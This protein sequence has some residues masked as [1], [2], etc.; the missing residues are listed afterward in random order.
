M[1]W[2]PALLLPIASFL[3]L[4][5]LLLL[6]SS[7]KGNICIL[8]KFIQCIH[9]IS[10]LCFIYKYHSCKTHLPVRI[11]S[12]PARRVR[13]YLYFLLKGIRMQPENFVFIFLE[14]GGAPNFKN[15]TNGGTRT[16][17]CARQATN[18]IQ[19][20]YTQLNSIGLHFSAQLCLYSYHI[21]DVIINI[22][23]PS[24]H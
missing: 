3:A 10:L 24:S 11:S 22:N 21:Y 16:R 14:M 2:T 8:I 20:D 4:L 7:L 5:C 15:C 17:L 1:E 13:L 19:L 9:H 18:L 12:R 6:L 23:H